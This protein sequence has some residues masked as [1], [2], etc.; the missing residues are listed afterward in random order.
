MHSALSLPQRNNGPFGFDCEI[1]QKENIYQRHW[2]VLK[3]ENLLMSV[4]VTCK[5]KYQFWFVEF[6]SLQLL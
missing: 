6:L 3:K 5:K 1:R 4:S 2:L